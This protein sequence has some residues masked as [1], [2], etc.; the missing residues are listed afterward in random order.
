MKANVSL[1]IEEK[2]PACERALDIV[3]SIQHLC[4]ISVTVYERKKDAKLF[5]QHGVVICPATFIDNELIFYGDFTR[6]QFL[7]QLEI[8][9]S[10]P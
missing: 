6:E 1:F 4:R 7:K 5:S 2:C 10:R 8:V 3:R 9:A